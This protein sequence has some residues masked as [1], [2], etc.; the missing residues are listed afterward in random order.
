M[1]DLDTLERLE[2]IRQ[3]FTLDPIQVQ[4]GG[5]AANLARVAGCVHNPANGKAVSSLLMESKFMIEWIASDVPSEIQ[6]ELV[7]LQLQLAVWSQQYLNSK[8]ISI[9]AERWSE[10]VLEMSGI[11]ADRS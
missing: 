2:I 3:R 4:L 8:E 10:R 11:R 7:E 1:S 5:L 6:E 9:Q